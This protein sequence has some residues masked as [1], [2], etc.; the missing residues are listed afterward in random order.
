MHIYKI[1]SLF[2]FIFPFLSHSCSILGAVIVI[3]GLYL[4]LWGKDED[5]NVS[6]KSDEEPKHTNAH[7]KDGLNVEP[8]TAFVGI[9]YYRHISRCAKIIDSQTKHEYCYT[10]GKKFILNSRVVNCN[11][12]HFLNINH[13]T[14]HQHGSPQEGK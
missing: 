8:W 9:D 11:K 13:L 12:I 7:I 14:L 3:L 10:L 1:S 4:L 2:F 5:E 6:K